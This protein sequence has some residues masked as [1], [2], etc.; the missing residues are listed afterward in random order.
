L[1]ALGVGLDAGPS[2]HMLFVVALFVLI[3]FKARWE[4]TMLKARY[5]EYEAYMSK[6]GMF[7]PRLNG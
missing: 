1:F 6:T 4:E 5:P 2:P 7:L 3:N